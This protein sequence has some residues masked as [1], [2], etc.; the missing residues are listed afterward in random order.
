MLSNF[1]KENRAIEEIL[2]SKVAEEIENN[3]IKKGLWTK[4]LSETVGDKIAT[5][6]LYIKLRVQ[7]LK[8]EQEFAQDSEIN[9]IKR[10]VSERRVAML[11][12]VMKT[13]FISLILAFI[14]IAILGHYVAW[15]G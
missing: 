7:N 4:A 10:K 6:A 2:Y 1:S 15:L 8:D 14:L 9:Q 13:I 12:K 5:Q 11:D 3:D